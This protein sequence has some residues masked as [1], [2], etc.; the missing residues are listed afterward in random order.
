MSLPIIP[1]IKPPWITELGGVASEHPLASKLGVD[2]LSL[3]GNA[4][5]AAITTSLALA[6][7]QPH[8]GGLGG[9][10]FAMVYI[11]REGRVYFIN[12]SGWAPRRLSRELLL[13]RGLNSIPIRG[14]LSPVIPG[15][16]AGLHALWKRFGTDEWK[17]LVRPVVETAKSGFPASPSFAKAIEL[18]RNDI[19]KNNDFKS[20]Y[21]I[22][23]KPWDIIRIEPLIKTFELIME[24]GPDAFYRG[25]IGEAVVNYVQSAGG[26]MEMSDLTEYEPEWRDP[27][28]IDY[29]GLT[30]YESPPNTQGI[31]TLMILRLLEELRV[32]VDAWSR[33]RIE[34]YLGIY[35]IA[36]ELRDSYVGDPR[37][38][39]IPI[40]KLLDPG[41]LMS[42]YKSRVGKRLSGSGDTTYFVVV[43]REGNVVSAIQSLYQHFGSLVTEPK[44][45]ITLNDRA[46]DF[47]MD[48]PNA[49]M[50]RKRPLHTLSTV[51]ITRNGEPKYALGTSGA[52]FRPQQHTLFI[53]NM[54]DHGLSPVEAI[55]APRFLWDRK[56]LIIEEGYEITGLTEPYQVIRYPGRTGVA[57][58]AAFLDNG[59]KLL[60]TDIRGDGLA[61]GQ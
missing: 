58:I 29:K 53:T 61:L 47:S 43:D 30:I 3:G 60:Y 1:G 46:S 33:N 44:Y 20:V 14:P 7:T 10:F 6:L 2:V 26:V 9:D 28:S 38:V 32:N 56:S 31:T 27:L 49:L 21:P 45:G 12:A 41:F 13:Q 4:I 22:N 57:S 37:F 55:D 36:Y 16:L 48:G 34:T 24:Y 51:I 35:R 42:A 5:D 52:H 8:L 40:N 39:E 25:E 54:V 23:A 59:R 15:L 19:A 17:S 50:P 18:L 11:A